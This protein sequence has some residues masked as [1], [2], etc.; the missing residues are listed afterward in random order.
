MSH[1]KLASGW[2]LISVNVDPTQEIQLNVGVGTLSRVGAL[3]RDYGTYTR[4]YKLLALAAGRTGRNAA[5]V[6][7]LA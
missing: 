1:V 2:A 4:F 3:S 7:P 5:V 6:F